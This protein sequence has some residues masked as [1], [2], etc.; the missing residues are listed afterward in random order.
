[1]YSPTD[2]IL[3]DLNGRD[4]WYLYEDELTCPEDEEEPPPSDDE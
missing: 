2:L 1:M 4:D 3:K